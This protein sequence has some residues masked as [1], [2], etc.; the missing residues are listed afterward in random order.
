MSETQ[1]Y[2][3]WQTHKLF[4]RQSLGLD[5]DI[6]TL[7]WFHHRVAF[8]LPK[9]P[10]LKIVITYRNQNGILGS[11]ISI[12]TEHTILA[13]IIYNIL[14]W[15]MSFMC[16]ICSLGPPS[17]LSFMHY[18]QCPRTSCPL[19]KGGAPHPTVPAACPTLSVLTGC[20]PHPSHSQVT[21][22]D[23]ISTQRVATKDW[24]LWTLT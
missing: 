19:G 24:Y 16:A 7:L 3:K 9:H 22:N 20:P 11:W 5:S 12:F 8:Y 14:L 2:T 10:Y 15:V 6:C 21:L 23:I 17:F 18:S 13:F 1:R 4:S